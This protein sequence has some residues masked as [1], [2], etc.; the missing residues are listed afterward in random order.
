MDDQLLKRSS[1][2][3]LYEV[4]LRDSKVGDLKSLS[5]KLGLSLSIEEMGTRS[6]L[7]VPFRAAFPPAREA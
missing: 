6:Y 2:F 5:E 4:P 7:K 1:P 3:P